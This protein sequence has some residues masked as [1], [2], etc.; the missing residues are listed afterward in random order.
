MWFPVA[1]VTSC[2]LAFVTNPLLGFV[3]KVWSS[4]V[5]GAGL[6]RDLPQRGSKA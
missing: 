4:V 2:V 6:P 5:V 1:I 3:R